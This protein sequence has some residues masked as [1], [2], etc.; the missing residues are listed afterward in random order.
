[1]VVAC[2]FG[3]IFGVV[4]ATGAF[5][6]GVPF[7]VVVVVDVVA[8]VVVVVT[9]VGGF[10]VMSLTTSGFI[11]PVVEEGEALLE[12]DIF[13]F[14]M[15]SSDTKKPFLEPTYNSAPLN[16][17]GLLEKAKLLTMFPFIY[18]SDLPF[19]Q[20]IFTEIILPL[21]KILSSNP[22]Q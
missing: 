8:V 16:I 22:T 1:V 5:T 18:S 20:D 6:I 17:L 21:P 14:E 7:I 2:F 10:V 13:R 11:E 4:V 3:S 15:E 9:V 19:D 12:K